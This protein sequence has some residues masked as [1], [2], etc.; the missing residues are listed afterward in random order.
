MDMKR[1]GDMKRKG[2]KGRGEGDIKREER[3]D[4]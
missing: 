4:M 1:E 3:G 2:C